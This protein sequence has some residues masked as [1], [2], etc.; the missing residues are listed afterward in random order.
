MWRLCK[1]VLH[2]LWE[3]W[4]DSLTALATMLI[5]LA[6]VAELRGDVTQSMVDLVTQKAHMLALILFSIP[7][8]VL[9]VRISV[10]NLTKKWVARWKRLVKIAVAIIALVSI[11]ALLICTDFGMDVSTL[12]SFALVLVAVLAAVTLGL[13]VNEAKYQLG[14]PTEEVE[15]RTGDA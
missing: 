13:H 7:A 6:A 9:V 8:L 3:L 1:R 14:M 5:L 2:D 15:E 11:I 12:N 4:K 10:Q